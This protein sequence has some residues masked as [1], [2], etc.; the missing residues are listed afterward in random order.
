LSTDLYRRQSTNG[1]LPVFFPVRFRR[2]LSHG[3]FFGKVRETS[4]GPASL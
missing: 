3:L 2:A 1:S 4:A